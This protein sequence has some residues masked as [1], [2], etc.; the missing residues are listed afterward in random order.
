MTDTTLECADCGQEFVFTEGEQEFYTAKNLPPPKY[1]LI[2]RGK[3]GA[4]SKDIGKYGKE[5][6]KIR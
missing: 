3:Y 1:C 4:Q 5:A 2:C 6:A